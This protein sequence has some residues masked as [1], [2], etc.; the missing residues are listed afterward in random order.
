MVGGGIWGG[1]DKVLYDVLLVH[2]WRWSASSAEQEA[3]AGI[4]LPAACT[5][6]TV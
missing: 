1:G 3:F 4:V 6:L 2:L 5:M